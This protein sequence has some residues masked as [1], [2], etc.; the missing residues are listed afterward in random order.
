MSYEC[1]TE[2]LKQVP[3]FQWLRRTVPRKVLIYESDGKQ[4]AGRLAPSIYL[5]CWA[6]PSLTGPQFPHLELQT[7]PKMFLGLQ[8]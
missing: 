3:S 4:R 7:S 1:V 2:S 8:R 5:T 6:T